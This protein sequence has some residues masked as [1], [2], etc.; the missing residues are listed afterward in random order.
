[1]RFHAPMLILTRR[2]GES[3]EINGNITVTVLESTHGKIR[4]GFD[5]PADVHILR[6]ELIDEDAGI[7]EGTQSL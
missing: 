4:L 2:I 7:V 5:A 3:V 6:S 1:M